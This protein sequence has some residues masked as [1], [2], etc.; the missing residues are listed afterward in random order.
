M[1]VYDCSMFFNENDIYEI[2]LNQHWDFVDK[3]VVVEAGETHTGVK[4]PLNFDH[5]RFKPY[6]DKIVYRSFDSFEETIEA[7]PEYYDERDA[8]IHDHGPDW[9]RDNYQGNYIFHVLKEI[10]A[11]DDDII[12]MTPPDEIIRKSAMEEAL[13]RF[14]DPSVY[15]VTDPSG[16]IKVVGTR[17]IFYFMLRMYVYKF[18]LLAF[19]SIEQGSISEF[20]NHRKIFPSLARA[21]SLK[22][23]TPIENAGWHFSY[24]D[25]TSGERVLQKMH[26]WAHARDHGR[27]VNGARRIDSTT[28]EDAISILENEFAPRIVPVEVGT[29]PDYVVNNIEKF[30]NYIFKS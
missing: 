30:E 24:A 22:T 29:H 11:K 21:C 28:P 7:H 17:P 25:N 10:G 5:E 27:G 3:F 14:K 13:N 8:W 19:E 1:A 12:L 20:G 26:S 9:I 4:K 2:R 15:D 16:R 6:A 18:N 23:H